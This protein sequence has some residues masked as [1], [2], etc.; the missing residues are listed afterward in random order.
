VVTKFLAELSDI[1]SN[2]VQGKF[3]VSA[4]MAET[5]WGKGKLE[6]QRRS[7]DRGTQNR[8]MGKG[9]GVI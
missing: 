1:Q 2:A 7:K 8:R 9:E 5:V 4:P 3:H 6:N